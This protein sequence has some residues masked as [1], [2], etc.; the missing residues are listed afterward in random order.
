MTS[1][2]QHIAVVTT[3]GNADEAQ[4]IARA[5]VQRRLAAC[6]Q[7][8][9]I[10]SFYAWDGAVQ[11]EPE[12]RLLCKTTGAQHDAVVAAIKELHSYELPAIHAL[13]LQQV[14]AAYG[15]WIQSHSTGSA[16]PDRAGDASAIRIRDVDHL[17]L[18]VVDLARMLGFYRDV[19]GCPVERR[20]ETVRLAPPAAR[21][22][23]EKAATS[24]ISV[25][26]SSR[27]MPQRSAANS[28]RLASPSATSARA[29]A[30]KALARRSTSAT[31]K[32]T[33]SS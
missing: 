11:N 26:A 31:R 17:V 28:R 18:R 29:T 30:P 12:W 9:V 10:E 22:R 4:R 32:A 27:S 14:D 21:R 19:L 24:I 23:A 6:V 5:L 16:E 33:R 13:A 3:V 1:P 2:T 20:D 15:A 7:I 25:C 8:S